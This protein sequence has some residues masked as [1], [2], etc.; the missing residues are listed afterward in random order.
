MSRHLEAVW[1]TGQSWVVRD[2]CRGL[3]PWEGPPQ[4]PGTL[5]PYSLRQTLPPHKFPEHPWREAASREMPCCRLPPCSCSNLRSHRLWEPPPTPGSRLPHG[6]TIRCPSDGF[7]L[8]GCRFG[9]L[10]HANALGKH[11]GSP[12]ASVLWPAAILAKPRPPPPCGLWACRATKDGGLACICLLL[13]QPLKQGC[14][15]QVPSPH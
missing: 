8:G 10:D 11:P 13:G 9:H 4:G 15:H 14:P 2:L 12:L 3:R 6:G 5:S 1:G 7:G